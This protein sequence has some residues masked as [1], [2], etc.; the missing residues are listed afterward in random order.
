MLLVVLVGASVTASAEA[1]GA[2]YQIMGI[3]AGW[4]LIG[5]A[6]A[7][8]V[9]IFFF[10]KK[11]LMKKAMVPLVACL[12]IG[13]ALVFIE[14]P[15]ANITGSGD[16][17]DFEVTGTAITSGTGYITS[18]VWDE[19]DMTLTVPLTV[20]DS[21]D[22]NLSAHKTGVN[23]TFDPIGGG[24]TADDIATINFASDYDFKYG[25]EYVLDEDSTGY[26]AIWTTTGGTEY[27]S[28]S[29]DIVASGTDWAQI[30]YTFVNG[31][32]G[33]WVTELDAVGDS[34]TWYITLSNGCG[35]WT[36]TI[37]VTAIVVSYTA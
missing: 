27:N 29:I 7:V 32:A 36:D 22:G 25:G 9:I 37:T 35:T 15:V 12:L 1:L 16:C 17:P 34:V 24:W 19:D 10:L 13:G 3:E 2:G 6:I 26:S 21:S 30:D 5:L 23:L 8:G 14:A 33:S 11:D 18:T 20:S 28:D 4:F 31:T